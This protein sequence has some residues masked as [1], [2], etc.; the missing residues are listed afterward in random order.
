[1]NT[2]FFLIDLLPSILRQD[3]I[4]FSNLFNEDLNFDFGED[5]DVNFGFDGGDFNVNFGFDGGDFNV[6]FGF[7]G[8]D[9]DVNFGFDKELV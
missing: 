3:F 9:F 2:T 5:F 1:M 4:S 8:G 6:N 7:G